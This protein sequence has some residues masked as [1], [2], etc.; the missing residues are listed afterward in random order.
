MYAMKNNLNYHFIRFLRGSQMKGQCCP[1]C[2]G[3]EACRQTSFSN[4][5]LTALVVW[6]ELAKRL[7]EEPICGECIADLRE[8][9]VERADEVQGASESTRSKKAG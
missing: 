8:V 1:R 9:L 7:I 5:A 6:G 4:A 2:G 3:D